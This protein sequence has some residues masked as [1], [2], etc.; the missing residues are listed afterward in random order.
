MIDWLE[1]DA[2]ARFIAREKVIAHARTRPFY[3]WMH[4]TV[5]ADWDDLAELYAGYKLLPRRYATEM[6][7]DELRLAAAATETPM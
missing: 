7:A 1:I 6:S 4:R 3:R 2:T 5:I